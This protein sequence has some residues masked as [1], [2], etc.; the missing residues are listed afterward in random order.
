MLRT[1]AVIIPCLEK[2]FSFILDT[3]QYPSPWSDGV[4]VPLFKSGSPD[5]PNNYRG[6]TITS[7]LA[8]LFNSILNNRL[9]SFIEE[10]KFLHYEQIGFRQGCRTSDYI[11]MLKTIICKQ[12]SKS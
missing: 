8:K 11:F 1:N 3:G 5:D 12:F 4:I 6:I 7:C 10:Q 9:V 2:L